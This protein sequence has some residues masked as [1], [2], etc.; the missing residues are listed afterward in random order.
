[1]ERVEKVEDVLTWVM[2]LMLKYFGI[3]PRSGKDKVSRKAL[4]KSQ[5]KPAR[6]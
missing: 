4:L 3:D 5:R 6:S 2:F 1:M